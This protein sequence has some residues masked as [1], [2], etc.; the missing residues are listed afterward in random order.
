M[1]NCRVDGWA[2]WERGLQPRAPHPELFTL[3][4]SCSECRG[5]VP[6][7]WGRG[8]TDPTLENSIE[9]CVQSH[10]GINCGSK[11]ASPRQREVGAILGLPIR[12]HMYLA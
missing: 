2:W 5:R 12:A 8:A 4:L 11:Q 9:H 3:G 10:G 1:G 6:T 7:T